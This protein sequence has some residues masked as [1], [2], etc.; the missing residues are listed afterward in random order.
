MH[1]TGLVLAVLLASTPAGQEPRRSTTART[2]GPA[3]L[4]VRV[5]DPAGTPIGGVKVTLEGPTHRDVRT[6]Q[7]R[8]ALE[9]L[10]SGTYRMRFER[11]GFVTLEREVV[12]RGG[13]PVD[14]KVTLTPAPEPPA[15]PPPPAAPAP[16]TAGP[17][18]AAPV[19]LDLPAFI[20]KN[21][22]GREPRKVSALGCTDEGMATLIQLRDP[23]AEHAHAD[24]DEYLYVIAGQ[25]SAR[26]T[27]RDQSL[28]AGFFVLVPR[29]ASH[30]LVA[31]GRGP[32]VLL[33][34]RP[35]ETCPAPAQAR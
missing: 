6:E 29:G 4:A 7:G 34:I 22:I 33:S 31:S 20:E 27:A 21:Y 9:N 17:S 10:P 32:L 24:S 19:L 30:A 3:T 26:I 2:S 15:P 8:I 23:L 14:V 25:G 35:G 5:T 18:D 16:P 12:A 13:A 1:I 11:D 28:T